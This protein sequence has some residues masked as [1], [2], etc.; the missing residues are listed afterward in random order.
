MK[1][2]QTSSASS[3]WYQESAMKVVAGVLIATLMSGVTMLS[4]ALSSDDPLVITDGQYQELRDEF[5]LTEPRPD[6]DG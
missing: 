2:T 3:R 6:D 4:L 1:P 5:R